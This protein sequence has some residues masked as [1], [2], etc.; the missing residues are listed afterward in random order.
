MRRALPMPAA[1]TDATIGLRRARA[2]RIAGLYA[3]TPDLAD[4]GELGARVAAALA[5]GAAAVQYRNKT[6][7]ARCRREQAMTLA[8]IHAARGALFIVNDDPALAAE[9]GADGVHVGEDDGSIAAAREIVGPDRIVGVSCYNDFARAQ[10]AVAAGAD[11][12]AFGSFFP[13][14]VKPAARRAD[15]E[16]LE[17]ARGLPV[18]VVA[19]GGITAANASTLFRA[20]ADAVAVISAVFDAPDVEAAASAIAATFSKSRFFSERAIHP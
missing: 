5:G 11:Y 3:V 14:A 20:G 7:D 9:I 4:I 17:Q 19:I 8:R 16:L 13:S 18:P 15:I 10:A 6:A 1:L 12:V 2:R